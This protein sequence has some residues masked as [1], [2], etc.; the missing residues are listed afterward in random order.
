ME[1]K[2]F[3]DACSKNNLTL[4]TRM[5]EKDRSIVN[6]K[7]DNG[8]TGLM[9]PVAH[10]NSRIVRRILSTSGVDISIR[11]RFG[12]TALHYG[13]FNNSVVNLQLLLDHHYCNVDFI[14]MQNNNGETAQMIAKKMKFK[15]AEKLLQHKYCNVSLTKLSSS[16]IEAQHALNKPNANSDSGLHEEFEQKINVMNCGNDEYEVETLHRTL[17]LEQSI[18]RIW[19][20]RLQKLL[21]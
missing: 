14:D 10:K 12:C 5:I 8:W 1:V 21:L 2:K 6:R 17:M 19:R 11:G 9:R 7:D 3:S 13:C 15:E 18:Q 16:K 4:V 20:H